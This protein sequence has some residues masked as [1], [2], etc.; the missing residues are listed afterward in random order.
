MDSL[1]FGPPSRTISVEEIEFAY[2]YSTGPNGI[3]P[4]DY[5]EPHFNEFFYLLKNEVVQDALNAGTYQTG[6]EH[7][8]EEGKAM[9]LKAH[10]RE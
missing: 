8:L 5:G 3:D 2:V 6:L 10:A 9:G 7:Y 1:P 4:A